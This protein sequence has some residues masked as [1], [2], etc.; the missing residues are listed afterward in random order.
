MVRCDI[1]IFT[2]AVMHAFRAIRNKLTGTTNYSRWKDVT[3]PDREEF[4]ERFR[5]AVPGMTA[6]GD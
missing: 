3:V 1:E 2:L 4:V 5:F 6:A